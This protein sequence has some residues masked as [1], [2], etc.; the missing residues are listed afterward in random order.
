MALIISS[1]G[2]AP[3]NANPRGFP[4]LARHTE[5]LSKEELQATFKEVDDAV[6]K[7]LAAAGLPFISLGNSDQGAIDMGDYFRK[8]EVPTGIVGFWKRWKFERAWY[9][10][11]AVGL[12]IPPEFAVPFDHEWGRQVRVNGDCACQGAEHW[13]EGFAIGNY[14]IDTQEGLNAFVFLLGRIH[15][16]RKG[17]K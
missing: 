1:P 4:N 17:V 15:K 12:G 8:G 7:E 5:G 13:G 16:P 10:Y 11:R 14:H 3:S 2:I 6:R 9:Y